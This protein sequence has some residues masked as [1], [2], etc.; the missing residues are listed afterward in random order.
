MK[1]G[2][3]YS[4]EGVC[5]AVSC[6]NSQ[7]PLLALAKGEWEDICQ[8]H[9]FEY[10]DLEEG[11]RG[12]KGMRNEFRERVGGERVK[13]ALESND[14]ATDEMAGDEELEDFLLNDGDA[15]SEETG[16]LGFGIDPKEMEEEMRGMKRAIYGNGDD[17]D[18]D[19]QEGK[20]DDEVEKLQAMMLKMQAVRGTYSSLVSSLY[21]HKSR[22]QKKKKDA[23]DYSQAWAQIYRKPRGNVLLL[24]Q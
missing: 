12:E 21:S 20:D 24:R 4:W 9:G 6:K 23:D 16:S 2:C 1:E 7:T 3:G 5:L 10:V 8:D 22:Y 13:E 19:D 14:W 15:A 17:D 18:D 11:G